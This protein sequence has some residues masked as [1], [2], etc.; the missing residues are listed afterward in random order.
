[1]DNVEKNKLE[2]LAKKT[3]A[4][5]GVTPV[6]EKFGYKIFNKLK[7]HNYEVYG[8][9]PKYDEVEGERLYKSLKELPLIP[10]CVNMVV[11]PKV[12]LS[13]LDEIH[14]L[15]IKYV[16]FQPGTFDEAVIDKAEEYGFNYVYYDCVLVALDS[17][18][19]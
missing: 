3:W 14:S 2:M 9:N 15:G 16:W 12:T 18:E 17:K 1:M 19:S 6:P 11:N 8:V 4:V 7:S 10:E 5:V 13:M